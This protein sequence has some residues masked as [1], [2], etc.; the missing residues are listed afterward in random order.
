VKLAPGAFGQWLAASDFI[1]R[2]VGPPLPDGSCVVQARKRT[3][4]TRDIV[5]EV[6][7][8]L[9]LPALDIAALVERI[10]AIY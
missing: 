8:R 2:S 5:Q 4:R 1:V 9:E 3:R 6:L 7:T 10:P